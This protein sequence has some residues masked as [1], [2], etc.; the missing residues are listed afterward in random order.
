MKAT[1]PK[2]SVDPKKRDPAQLVDKAK[3]HWP[4]DV[5]LESRVLDLV[6]QRGFAETKLAIEYAVL[7]KATGFAYVASTINRWWLDGF[8]F[9][10]IQAE[11]RA[12][13]TKGGLPAEATMQNH[14]P[15]TPKEAEQP[16]TRDEIR[17]CLEQIRTADR[18]VL[19]G[20]D[21]SLLKGWVHLGFAPASLL[22]E[23]SFETCAGKYA[24]RGQSRQDTPAAGW[25]PSP[26][27]L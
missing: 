20:A 17:L 19:R 22:D 21:P 1:A 7:K 23:F 6:E 27:A 4:K 24:G 8:D 10:D 15:P 25:S 2:P 13:G 18:R 14:N 26:G 5:N 3:E 11:V 12:A 9:E 16:P